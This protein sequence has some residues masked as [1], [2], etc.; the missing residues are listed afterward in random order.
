MTIDTIT[1]YVSRGIQNYNDT[2]KKMTWYK[3]NFNMPVPNYMASSSPFTRYLGPFTLL[4]ESYS[5]DLSG[6]YPGY[7]VCNGLAVF[8]FENNGASTY[9]INTSL[10][11][12][13]TDSS[14][15]TLVPGM[16]GTNFSI[17]LAPGYYTEVWAGL[18]IGIA[19]WEINSNSTYYFRASASGTPT[20]SSVDTAITITNCPSTTQLGSTTRGYIWVDGNNL[21]FINS[22]QWQHQIVGTFVSSS[23][24]ASASGH[25]WIDTSNELHWVTSTGD[26]YKA[27]WKIQQFASFYSNGAQSTLYAGTTQAGYIWVDSEF[28][29]THISYIGYDGYKYLIGSGDYPYA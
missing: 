12:S 5:Y 24:G 20:I 21:A 8:D 13:W 28:G 19:S 16:N 2:S 11:S 14:L 27:P 17:S 3:T 18:N 22:N 7:E 10:Y 9:N 6:F 25:I 15:S 23:P 1:S 29:G 26:D 4:T